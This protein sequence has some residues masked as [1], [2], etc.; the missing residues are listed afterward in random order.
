MPREQSIAT[1]LRRS[2]GKDPADDLL[3]KIDRLVAKRAQKEAIE[4]AVS[5]DIKKQ[6]VQ[7]VTAAVASTI[8]PLTPDQVAAVQAEVRP[9]IAGIIVRLP[10]IN[11]GVQT[12]TGAG[13]GAKTKK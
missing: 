6:F 3:R 11:R 9:L 7:Q 2:L 10:A 5:A 13:R 1:L 12:M 4:K 8:G